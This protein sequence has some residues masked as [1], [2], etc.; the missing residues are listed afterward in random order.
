M[1]RV[2]L[3]DN[4]NWQL[5]EPVVPPAYNTYLKGDG[6]AYIDTGIYVNNNYTIK[7]KLRT[8]QYD[9]QW[10][11]VCAAYSSNVLDYQ[12]SSGL[13]INSSKNQFGINYWKAGG[14]RTY[15]DTLVPYTP[16]TIYEIEW[17]I[18]T[19]NILINGE[20][21]QGRGNNADGTINITWKVFWAKIV[22]NDPGFTG[23]IYYFKMFDGDN[24]V[25]DLVP[26]SNNG[27]IGMKDTLTNRIF[28]N[29]GGGSFEYGVDEN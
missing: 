18:G 28:T 14:G 21:I 1:R 29:A 4:R 23:R 6:T 11:Q 5:P 10:R 19:G 7:M 20:L 12:P 3:F 13:Y 25:L 9:G 15:T 26:Y 8:E 22:Q 27:T 2:I 16:Y 17:Q 24:L